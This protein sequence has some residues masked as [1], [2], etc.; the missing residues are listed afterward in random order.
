MIPTVLGAVCRRA[1]AHADASGIMGFLLFMAVAFGFIWAI[2]KTKDSAAG[3]VVLLGFT[4]FMGLML[5][6]MLTPH[7]GLS[8]TAAA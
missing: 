3:V 1:D 2:E 6:P 5:T 7:P 4:F 8:A